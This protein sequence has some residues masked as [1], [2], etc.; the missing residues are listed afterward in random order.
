MEIECDLLRIANRPGGVVKTGLV[1]GACLN[2][3]MIVPY[4]RRLIDLGLLVHVGKRYH[5]TTKGEVYAKRIMA[6]VD[7]IR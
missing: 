4:L 3:K 2:F 7:S 1:Y 6:A 5:T